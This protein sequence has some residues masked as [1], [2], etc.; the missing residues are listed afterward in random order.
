MR[1]QS[2]GRE[3]FAPQQNTLQTKSMEIFKTHRL[4][5]AAAEASAQTIVAA[6]SF[7]F[8]LSFII[9]TGGTTKSLDVGTSLTM[10]PVE[11]SE[12]MMR[13]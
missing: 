9:G 13:T 2:I 5:V 1:K 3:L 4:S 7:H 10:R 6:S 8:C 11:R 12:E